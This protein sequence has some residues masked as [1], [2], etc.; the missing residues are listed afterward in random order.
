MSTSSI[1][2]PLLTLDYI[3]NEHENK[4]FDRK[5]A[6]V[7]PA[8]LAPLVS[9]FANADGGTIVLGISDARR[10]LEG[11]ALVGEERINDFINAPR[12]CCKPMPNYQEEYLDITNEEGKPD[13]LLLLHISGSK[14]GVIRTNNDETWLRI[15]DRTKQMLGE[16]L[17][18]LEYAKNARRYED[19][20]H[21]DAQIDDL[22]PALLAKFK[23]HIGA[24]HLSDEQVL[25]ARHFLKDVDGRPRLT[26]AAVLLFAKDIQALYPNCRVRFIRYDGTT[27]GVG[28]SI[29][30]TKDVSIE[31]SLLRL[32]DKAKEF[33]ATQLREFT[34]LNPK[35]GKFEVI[36]EYPEFPWLEGLINAICHRE[37]AMTGA[38]IK[39]CMFDDR[40][41]ISSPGQLAGVVTLENIRETRFSRNPVISR[42]LTE[43]EWVRELNEGV[44]RIYDEMKGFSLDEP[45][46]I[47]TPGYFK[48][49]LRNN[50][51]ARRLL[52]GK[53]IEVTGE[54]QGWEQL[55]AMERK[56]LSIISEQGAQSRAQLAKALGKA[57]KTVSTHLR[58][59]VDLHYLIPVGGK[60]DP[61]RVY[62]VNRQL[63]K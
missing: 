54:K 6:K 53:A 14:D 45:T 37:Y 7:R 33:I 36:P 56:I 4:Y 13:R 44:P 35:T 28:T 59:L 30:I 12:D 29:N 17:R 55:D 21:P 49:V 18:N 61:N 48:L 19:E 58:H 57:N 16:N 2:N 26:N 39:V 43:C 1:I 41:E 22:A 62:E 40:L 50:I 8:E 38:F 34:K 15:G 11:I 52:K 60:T 5:S 9:A 24:E 46:F 3:K 51:E 31:Y 23:S 25:R 47:E 42:V 63:A 32:I 27:A 10:E 20:L